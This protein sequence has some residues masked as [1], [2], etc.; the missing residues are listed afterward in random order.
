ME[1]VSVAR[2]IARQK[3]GIKTKI[4]YFK[5]RAIETNAIPPKTVLGSKLRDAK[6]LKGR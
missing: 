6:T 1:I 5:R 2:K 4:V 3:N